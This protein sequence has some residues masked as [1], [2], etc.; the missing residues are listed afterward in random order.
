MWINPDEEIENALKRGYAYMLFKVKN[1][2]VFISFYFVFMLV[3]T[4]FF[5]KIHEFIY[6]FTSLFLHEAGHIV[7]IGLL[8]EKINIFYIIP[9]GFSCRLKNQSKMEKKKMLKIL[10]A[11][12]VTSF[13][14][15]GL[16]FF[17]TKDFAIINLIIGIFN[18]LP[19]GSLDGGRIF[20]ILMQ[21]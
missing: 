3:W 11:G 6:C 16:A 14:V 5:N 13:I 18:L 15:A 20:R 19:L 8:K 4:I 7:L 2:Y 12:P 17:W 21:K 1:T 9:F 10:W